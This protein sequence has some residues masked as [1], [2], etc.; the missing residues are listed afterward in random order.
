VR[1][2]HNVIVCCLFALFLN[3]FSL[4]LWAYAY[5]QEH[6]YLCQYHYT[7]CLHYHVHTSLITLLLS[8]NIIQC[9]LH[10]SAFWRDGNQKEQYQGCRED[11][12]AQSRQVV[13]YI[14]KSSDLGEGVQSCSEASVLLDF[15]VV[16]PAGN[17]S[18]ES[19][20]CVGVIWCYAMDC[21]FFSGLNWWTQFSSLLTVWD[22]KASPSAS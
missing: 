3:S 16:K 13:W 6:V 7:S 5:K 12:A 14:F 11:G 20:V 9:R 15:C 17:T 18:S 4:L 10:L 19:W 8:W 2:A 22:E 1:L 21:L